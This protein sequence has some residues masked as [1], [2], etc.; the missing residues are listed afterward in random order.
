MVD[1]S[2]AIRGGLRGPAAVGAFLRGIPK[3]APIYCDEST[4]EVLSNVDPNRFYRRNPKD[5]GAVD[6]IVESGRTSGSVYIATWMSKLAPVL[7]LGELVFRPDATLPAN[8]GLGVVRI[9]PRTQ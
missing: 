3:G 7:P 6:E 9:A 4:V 8:E 1:W 2:N 5:P